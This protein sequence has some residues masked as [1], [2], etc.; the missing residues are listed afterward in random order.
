MR[1]L[2]VDD[3]VIFLKLVKHILTSEGYDVAEATNLNK[4][5]C[6]LNNEK[7]D[8]IILDIFLSKEHG[9]SFLQQ[10]KGNDNYKDIPVLVVSSLNKPMII[11]KALK[12][13]AVDYINKPINIQDLKNKCKLFLE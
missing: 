7:P 13:G 6:I 12:M 5:L 3:S 9:L 4:A 2:L 11:K 1:V 8:L 10:T